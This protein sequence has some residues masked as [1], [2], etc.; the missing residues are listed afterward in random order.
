MK[1]N[2]AA[3]LTVILLVSMLLM[4]CSGKKSNDEANQ[5]NTVQTTNTTQQTEKKVVEADPTAVAVVKEFLQN[6]NYSLAELIT[7]M[8]K[9]SIHQADTKNA[10][11]FLEIDFSIQALKAAQSFFEGDFP[12][13]RVK[14]LLEN[15]GYSAKEVKFAMENYDSE[16]AVALIEAE[17]AKFE[18]TEEETALLSAFHGE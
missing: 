7:A 11:E 2:L 1:K 15:S 18:I 5:Q 17:M 4:G 12:E 8:S 14:M 16:N 6:G 3:I 9:K 10:A 13:K